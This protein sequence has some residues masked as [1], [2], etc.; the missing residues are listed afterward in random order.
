MTTQEERKEVARRLR[1]NAGESP[2]WIVPWAVF[3]DAQ[4]HDGIALINRLADLIDPT[5]H[6]FG[7][8]VGTNG[9]GYDFACSACGWCGDVTDA[10]YCPHCGARVV[11][12]ND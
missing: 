9:E 2:E 1:N 3:N 7:G 12:C 5:C 4:E 10:S 6:D 8:E 11:S